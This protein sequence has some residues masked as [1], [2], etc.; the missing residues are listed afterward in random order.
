[1]DQDA[2][3][4][5]VTD[6]FTDLELLR[7]TDGPGA[8]DTFIYYDP[9]HDLDLTRSMPFATLVTKDYQGFD[10]SSQLGRS[11]V[12]RLNIGVGRD[13]FRRLFGYAPGED[14]P[15][16]VTTAYDHA[17]LDRLMPHPI[18]APQSWVSVLNPSAETFEAV[19]PLLAEAYARVA[20]RHVSRQPNRD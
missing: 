13:T 7:P 11:G 2:I 12:F 4:E 14:A 3:I 17:A 20:V 16:S 8:G 5:Y 6:T 9:E 15:G 19:K 10:E 1:M 18:Y